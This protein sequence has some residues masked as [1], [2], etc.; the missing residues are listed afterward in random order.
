MESSTKAFIK[1]TLFGA[2]IGATLGILYAP[3]AGKETREDIKHKADE[4]MH[5]AEDLYLKAKTSVDRKIS[6]VKKLG[7]KIDK[8]AYEKLVD[9]VLKDLK[10]NQEVTAEAGKKLGEQLKEDWK[11]VKKALMA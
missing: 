2:A 4:L 3:K 8:T 10:N 9:E 11:D 5:Q 7:D 6:E 1:G